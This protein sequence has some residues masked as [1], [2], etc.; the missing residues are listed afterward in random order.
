MNFLTPTL[1]GMPVIP[2]L[3]ASYPMTKTF[4]FSSLITQALFLALF[5]FGFGFSVYRSV[6]RLKNPKF[7]DEDEEPEE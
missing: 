1:G 6:K 2:T 5:A 3:P 4:Y 7:T